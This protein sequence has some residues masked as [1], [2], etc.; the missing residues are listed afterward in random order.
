MNPGL[1]P[2]LNEFHSQFDVK[3]SFSREKE[4][5]RLAEL[6]G[7]ILQVSRLLFSNVPQLFV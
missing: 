2:E 6:D 5:T 7:L 1:S 4:M 3:K